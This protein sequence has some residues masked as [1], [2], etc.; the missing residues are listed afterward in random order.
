MEVQIVEIEPIGT[1]GGNVVWEWHAFDHLCHVK[2]IDGPF[3][4]FHGVFAT[5]YAC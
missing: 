1:S 2:V 4:S 5:L 3:N